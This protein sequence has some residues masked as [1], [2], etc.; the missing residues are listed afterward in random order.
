MKKVTLKDIAKALNTT[1]ATVSRALHNK[2]GISDAMKNRVKEAANLY[3][4][5]PNTL[6]LS[7]KFHKSYRIGV[8]F[9]KL[10]HYYVTQI[11][12]GMLQESGK[13]GY[14]MLIVESNYNPYKEIEYIKEF[15]ELNVDAIL[16]LPS[17]KLEL[18]KDKLENLINYDVPFLIIDRLINL[19][20]K[21]VPSIATDDYGGVKNHLL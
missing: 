1:I 21:K 3:S 2:P 17:R 11:L 8:I 19:E 15:Y 4:Y 9:P 10:S 20:N 18:L 16:I 5:K 14:K 6:A 7:L 13:N 12:S